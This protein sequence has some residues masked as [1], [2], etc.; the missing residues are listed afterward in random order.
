MTRAVTIPSVLSPSRGKR[1]LRSSMTQTHHDRRR[2]LL[3]PGGMVEDDDDAMRK[4]HGTFIS[5]T[6]TSGCCDCLHDDPRQTAPPRIQSCLQF[7]PRPRHHHEELKQTEALLAGEMSKLSV[8]EMSKALDDVHCVGQTIIETPE[9]IQRALFEFGEEALAQSKN[10]YKIALQQNRKYVEGE[11]FR[12]KFLRCN[13]FKI[14]SSVSQMMKF[15]QYKAKY[16]GINKLGRDI[17]LSDLTNEDRDLLQSGFFH[18]QQCKD[19]CG[20]NVVWF[21]SGF[22][23]RWTKDSM[24]RTHYFLNF[25]VLSSNP[26]V[27]KRG[28]VIIYYDTAQPGNN[29]IHR[30]KISEHIEVLGFVNAIPCRY[31]GR[32]FCLK[33]GKDTLALNNAVVACATRIIPLYTRVRTRLHY[34]SDMELQY[35]L[36]DHGISLKTCPVDENGV[37]LEA[38]ARMWYETSVENGLFNGYSNASGNGSD[39]SS[40]NGGS[41]AKIA[42][43]VDLQV[44]Q[45]D[46]LLGRGTVIQSRQGNIRF[47]KFVAEHRAAYDQA[48]YTGKGRMVAELSQILKSNGVRFLKGDRDKQWIECDDKE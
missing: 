13:M 47:R 48:G 16:F 45:N 8:E 21:F 12:L 6:A 29:V 9:L 30:L 11:A 36:Q 4:Q 44:R 19:R 39:A 28:A 31:S 22:V 46:V 43:S 32:H 10:I 26:E 23:G 25:N 3:S 27:Q 20:R 7:A 14:K 24:I 33:T 15:L 42:P 37:V 18:V 5:R 41:I 34:G 1:L 17:F 2:R 38:V 40:E 35:T